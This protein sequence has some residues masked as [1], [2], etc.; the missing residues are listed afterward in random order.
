MIGLEIQLSIANLVT[1]IQGYSIHDGPG[2][3]TVVFLKGC[4]LACRWCSNPECISPLPE[5]GFIKALCTKCGKCAGVC[6]VDALFFEA[7]Q[8]PRINRERCTGCGECS[9][10]CSYKAIV[11]YGKPMTADEV[12]DAVSRDKIF[13]EASGGGVT[14]SGGE[15]LLQP[16][17]VGELFKKCRQAG[18]HTCIETSGQATES[19]LRQVLPFTDC[20][21]Y[22]LKHM[23]SEKHRQY[24]GQPNDLVLSNAK[25]VAASRVEALFRMPLIPGVNDNKQNIKETA[26]FLRGLGASACRIEL[27]PYHRLGKGKYESLD[28][29]YP[30]PEVLSPEPEEIESVKKAFEDNGIICTVSR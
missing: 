30:L 5:V 16:Q 12:F 9:Q 15:A 27:M 7:D 11:L 1:N 10:A 24:T 26:E 28:R 6:P 20:V 23:N 29:K 4:G 22:D 18:I 8:M 21:L 25:L 14:V 17:F 3:R 13:Y 19:A 2:I